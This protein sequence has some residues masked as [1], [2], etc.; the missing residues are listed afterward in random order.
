MPHNAIVGAT[1][2]DEQYDSEFTIVSVRSVID[3]R[4]PT[5]EEI[6]VKMNYEC[7]RETQSVTLADFRNVETIEV[8]EVPDHAG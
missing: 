8:V 5:E 6:W 4:I 2:W 7:L 3:H 1:Y